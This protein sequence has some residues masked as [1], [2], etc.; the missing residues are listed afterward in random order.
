VPRP[1]PRG[2][3]HRQPYSMV[4]QEA[5]ERDL[6]LQAVG[7]TR[8]A[9]RPIEAPRLSCN[10]RTPSVRRSMDFL[11]TLFRSPH[12]GPRWRVASTKDNQPSHQDQYRAEHGEA[13]LEL[14]IDDNRGHE[15]PVTEKRREAGCSHASWRPP[16][17]GA[18]RP[19]GID[20]PA[21]A[22]RFGASRSH[23]PQHSCVSS[24][25]PSP[26]FYL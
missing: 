25:V 19:A 24:S 21:R 11:S 26:M 20:N 18:A 10:P 5:A 23:K 15:D 17:S 9:R 16:S 4:R 2:R 8:P 22:A 7:I 6:E 13:P 14:R 12:R 1:V 3:G